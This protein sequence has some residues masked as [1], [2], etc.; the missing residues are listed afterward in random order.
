[1]TDAVPAVALLFDDTELG[2]QLRDAL[3]E[4]GARIVHEGG[5]ASL[6]RQRLQ[7]VGADVLVV[8]L[9]DTAEDALDQLY[10]LIDGDRPRMVFND[11]QATRALAGWDRDRWARHLAVKVLQ[12]GDIDPPR[13]IDARAVDVPVAAKSTSAEVIAVEGTSVDTDGEPTIDQALPA[14]SASAAANAALERVQRIN[15]ES[16]SLSAEL[17]ALLASAEL[18][19]ADAD[20]DALDADAA[21]AT[22][23]WL[24]G[25]ADPVTGAATD[26]PAVGS[27]DPVFDG[28]L[29]AGLSADGD[30]NVASGLDLPAAT[31]RAPDNWALLDDD[32]PASAILPRDRNDPDSFGV[33]KLSAADYLAPDAEK[34]ASNFDPVMNLEL[35]SMEEAVAPQTVQ[36]TREMHLDELHMALSRL[37]LTGAAADGVDAAVAFF[38]ALPATSRLTFLHT[39]H[40]GQQSTAALVAQLTAVCPLPV[41]V[42]ADSSFTRPGE[43]LV[44]PPAHQVRVH[45]DG[46]VELQPSASDA[47]EPSID[48]NFT[49][50]AEGFG[51]DAVGIVFSGHSVDAVAGAQAIHDRGGSVWVESATAEYADMVS[52]VSAE[53][54]VNF[55]GTPQELAAHLIEV[56]S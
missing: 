34:V 5:I 14:S 42:A 20:A 50:A 46:R 22:I 25:E 18:P 45:R 17:E 47:S 49:M 15:S 37:I 4:R 31:A 7:E 28:S 55:S 54:L 27:R 48:D 53:G 43:V 11:A 10:D 41:K 16:E 23:A 44:A 13:P 8:N 32:A 6:S 19:G 26:M 12:A 40:L 56:F 51:R 39:Q 21:F 29:T 33:E 2:A 3:C 1:M 30:A 9:D 36:V 38:A 35:V 52:G 24:D